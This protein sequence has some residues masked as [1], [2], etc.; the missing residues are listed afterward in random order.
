M[1]CV[2]ILCNPADAPRRT[3]VG[4]GSADKGKKKKKAKLTIWEKYE[5]HKQFVKEMKDEAEKVEAE[6][7]EAQAVAKAA[8]EDSGIPTRPHSLA[9][10]T[11]HKS[12]R[13]LVKVGW[14]S[15]SIRILVTQGTTSGFFSGKEGYAPPGFVLPPFLTPQARLFTIR[16]GKG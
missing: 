1:L 9:A 16:G 4:A 3:V 11:V 5:L 13:A 10:P 6:E 2:Y 15:I 14:G 7:E 8:A 12:R